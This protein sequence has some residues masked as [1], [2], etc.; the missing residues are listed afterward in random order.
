MKR[1]AIYARVSIGNGQHS[2]MQ[3][4]ELRT[5]C[6]RR[7]W[8]VA[9]EFVDARISG[10]KESIGLGWTNSS[11]SSL[12]WLPSLIWPVFIRQKELILADGAVL[13]GRF[14]CRNPLQTSNCMKKAAF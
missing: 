9:G 13:I 10:A 3:L 1:A 7:G 12:V 11:D 4:G 8:R 5:Y 14:A 6:E 2:E